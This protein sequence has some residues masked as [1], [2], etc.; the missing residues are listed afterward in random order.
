[1]NNRVRIH[2]AVGGK[3]NAGKGKKSK[4][5]QHNPK[6]FG[7][8]LVT[9]CNQWMVICKDARASVNGVGSQVL[10]VTVLSSGLPEIACSSSLVLSLS[11]SRL[12]E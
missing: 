8:A 11:W 1:M 6:S 7:Q 5:K 9:F 12:S 2:T 4:V 3:G 10:L